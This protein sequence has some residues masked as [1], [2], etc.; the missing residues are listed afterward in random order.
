MQE[1]HWNYFLAIEEDLE[2]LSRYIDLREDNFATY[3]IETAKILMAASQEVDV[4][5]K[6]I[7]RHHKAKAE[8][9]GDYFDL[10]MKKHPAIFDAKVRLVHHGLV[11]APYK[12]WTRTKPPGW[13]SANNKVKH[14]RDTNF[15]SASL[16]N[17]IDAVSALLLA[18]ICSHVVPAPRRDARLL[19]PVGWTHVTGPIYGTCYAIPGEQAPTS[20]K[21]Q[22]P[23]PSDGLGVYVAGKTS[24][25]T[26]QIALNLRI[27][28]KTAQSVDMSKVTLRYWY[29]DQGLGTAL[30]LA[31]DYV[32]IGYSNPGRV[33][34]GRAVAAPSPVAGADHYLELSFTGTLAA[35]GDK[36]HKDQFNIHVRLHTANYRGAV[37]VTNDYSYNGGAIG[38]NDKIT[39][40]D[41]SGKV[42]WGV[43]PC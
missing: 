11:R 12:G 16:G 37:N 41:K 10:M 8:S 17:V 6:A 19:T 23:P 43:A 34:A 33:T 4:L 1:S 22:T 25:N 38:Y 2:N 21:S 29:Q 9:I 42:I 13:W 14:E 7:C 18:N 28:N 31:A 27:D 36:A 5:L 39:L 40:H 15:S 35:E 20:P 30:V 3:S 24:G 32:S 26:G